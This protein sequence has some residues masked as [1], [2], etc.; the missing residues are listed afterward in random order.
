MEQGR[1]LTL[2]GHSSLIIYER[3]I[4]RKG[5]F[6]SEM[7]PEMLSPDTLLIYTKEEY[8]CRDENSQRQTGP[9]RA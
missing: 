8:G 3:D 1:S 6:L 5:L 7:L 9:G 4:R 2:L